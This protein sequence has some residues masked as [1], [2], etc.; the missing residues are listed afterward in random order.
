MHNPVNPPAES[1]AAG[2]QE[3]DGQPAYPSDDLLSARHE[4]ASVRP[5][6]KPRSRLA[7]LGMVLLLA[8]VVPPLA[9]GAYWQ[10][11]NAVPPFSLS[12]PSAPRPNGYHEATLA[13]EQLQRVRP[14]LPQEW[15]SA[16][17]R[18][19]APS[20]AAA[21]PALEKTRQ[22]FRSDWAAP[23]PLH[24]EDPEAVSLEPLGRYLGAESRLRRLR[25]DAA[26]ALR[27]S[28]DAM[29]LGYRTSQGGDRMEGQS[30]EEVGM[31]QA[32]RCLDS[33]PR[34]AIAS[35]L[36]RVRRLRLDW[37]RATESLVIERQLM[38][39]QATRR[40]QINATRTLWQQ[41]DEL[42]QSS[43]S[44]ALTT[45]GG[46][47]LFGH[48]WETWQQVLIPR[49]HSLAALD[50]RYQE[51][52]ARASGPVRDGY[53]PP[54]LTDPWV[55]RFAQ[56]QMG[57]YRWEWARHNLALLETALAVRLFRLEHG[58]YP[59]RLRDIEPGRLPQ[60][61]EDAWDQPIAYR[62][63]DGRPVIYSFGRDGVD[64]GGKAVDP[65]TMVLQGHG[66]AVWG[67]LC[68]SDWPNKR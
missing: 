24:E 11:V 17:A 58:H 33:A 45:A 32:E 14:P 13:L 6:W 40:L 57:G 23:L 27:C 43:Q 5:T 16:P 51:L 54:L 15:R 4:G 36:I 25:G 41:L 26:G 59:R 30:Y 35:E 68:S 65:A 29:E 62:L 18:K 37:P 1:A 42:E 2:R 60:I 39:A 8:L 55:G 48:R 61:P 3:Q 67:K 49:A 53:G 28:V 22:A 19:L 10:Y 20:L 7:L 50:R 38:L 66:D 34:S 63:R 9:A 21:A 31:E 47:Q 56:S 52:M 12:L 46:P 64:D 44:L